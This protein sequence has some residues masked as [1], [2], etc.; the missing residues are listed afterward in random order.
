M[1]NPFLVFATWYTERVPCV[2]KTL[3]KSMFQDLIIIPWKSQHT[4]SKNKKVIVFESQTGSW[5]PESTDHRGLAS[6]KNFCTSGRYVKWLHWLL[7]FPGFFQ[8][9][10][11][12]T[13]SKLKINTRNG[14]PVKFYVGT[15]GTGSHD[16]EN[17]S[18][19]CQFWRYFSGRLC[20]LKKYTAIYIVVPPKFFACGG[21][22]I[23]FLM[24]LK[25]KT[26][27]RR[28]RKF[29]MC[30]CF[31]IHPKTLF[32]VVLSAFWVHF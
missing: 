3:R 11:D 1:G 27:L 29:F 24:F 12:E 15:G 30:L 4:V 16:K 7:H 22:K 14:F 9:F 32:L 2:E 21:P 28:R 31:R 10:I 25:Q 19:I 20:A 17:C 6:L 5:H 23:V 18:V 8:V 13:Y 26:R